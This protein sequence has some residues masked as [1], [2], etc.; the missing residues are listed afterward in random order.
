MGYA[1]EVSVVAM[2][3]PLPM[4]EQ[5]P[6]PEMR[7]FGWWLRHQL[8]TR[9]W[10]QS[11]FSR[12]SGFDTGVVSRWIADRRRPDLESAQRIADALGVPVDVV[13]LRL[14][15]DPHALKPADERAESLINEIRRLDLTP[16]RVAALEA[17]IRAWADMDRRRGG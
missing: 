16:D 1:S 9:G 8:A 6:Q 11:E 5:T 4:T 15:L 3:L 7:T 17:T 10:S 12:R 13:L 2:L 14:G